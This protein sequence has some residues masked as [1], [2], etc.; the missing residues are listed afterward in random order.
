MK[1]AKYMDD[2][3]EF[4]AAFP[5]KTAKLKAAV[6]YERARLIATHEEIMAGVAVYRKM[7]PSYADW[8]HPATFLN[9]GRW[10]DEPCSPED[11]PGEKSE[12]DRWLADMKARRAAKL[13]VVE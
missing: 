6:A 5:R 12:L 1:W 7:R 2:F 8:C 3:N 4:W 13:R 11:V 10:M 9:Q